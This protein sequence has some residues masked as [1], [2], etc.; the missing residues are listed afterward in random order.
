MQDSGNRETPPRD[1]PQTGEAGTRWNSVYDPRASHSSKSPLPPC[2]VFS[3]RDEG[4]RRS[5]RGKANQ[6]NNSL[7]SAHGGEYDECDVRD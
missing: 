3:T 7:L 6:I 4:A 2:A 1:S 5:N